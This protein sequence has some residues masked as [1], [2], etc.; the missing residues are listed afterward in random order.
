MSGR[1]SQSV[2][3]GG[4]AVVLLDEDNGPESPEV[5][6]AQHCVATALHVLPSRLP[7]GAL[8]VLLGDLVERLRVVAG[9]AEN[10]RPAVA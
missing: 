8:L 2:A 10:G 1:V 6:M 4:T 9:L 5:V 7:E 3:R